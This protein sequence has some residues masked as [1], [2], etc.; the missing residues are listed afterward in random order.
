MKNNIISIVTPSFNQGQFIEET[1]K[2]VLGQAGNFYIDYIIADGGS[3]DKSVEI[4]KKYD[5]LIK[6]NQYP[7]KCKGV[8]M[9]WWSKKDKGQTNALNEGFKIAKGELW[10]WI[11]S[12]DYYEP[13]IFE[14][15]SKKHKENPDADLF[16]G[17]IY[18]VDKENNKTVNETRQGSYTDL[19]DF[20]GKDLYIFQPSTF[21]TRRVMKKIGP[22]D[23]SLNYVMDYDLWIRM[24]KDSK[25][26]YVKKIL[27]NFR[28]WENSKT[29]SQEKKFYEEKKLVRKKYGLTMFDK[30]TIKKLTAGKTLSFFRINTPPLY[31]F[32]KRIFYFFANKTRY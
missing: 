29:F 30:K 3:T 11:N 20:T 12:D 28:I 21:F 7:I 17:D 26:L 25:I 24:L 8:E 22:L 14:Y 10:A 31:N 6:N 4:I 5:E 32:A 19:A 2:S 13:D 15:I 27:A 23:E 16:Y 9:R 1:I 18:I